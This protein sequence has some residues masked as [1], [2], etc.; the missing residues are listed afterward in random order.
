MDFMKLK[1]A[2][3]VL[4]A[5]MFTIGT[6]SFGVGAQSSKTSSSTLTAQQ[7]KI[8]SQNQS[9]V[10]DAYNAMIVRSQGNKSQYYDPKSSTSSAATMTESA[11][12]TTDT[13]ESTDSFGTYPTRDGVMLVTADS[14]SLGYHYG[15]AGIIWTAST[16]VESMPDNGVQYF[17][18]DWD[19]R[20]STVEG[21]TCSET[22]ADQDNEASNWCARQVGKPYNWNFF[23]TSTRNSFY[24]SQLV[25]ASFHDLYGIDIDQNSSV[26]GAIVPVDLPNQ[27]NIWI[28]YEK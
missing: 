27:S 11:M 22:T 6:C 8:V 18:N 5:A 4:I 2:G 13:V 12:T 19:S 3:I 9:K 15:H 28:I 26:P 24:C 7:Q 21:I 20:Y 16:T 10:D 23:Y 25:W 1:K 14:S 17:D